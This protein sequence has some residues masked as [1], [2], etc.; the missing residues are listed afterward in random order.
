MS[1]LG[2]LLSGI[3]EELRQ[4]LAQVAEENVRRAVSAIADAPRVLVAG[5]GRSGLAVRAFAMRLMH[6]GKDVFVV[7]DVTTPAIQEGDLLLIGSGSG[8]TASLVAAADK[9][10]SLGAKIALFTM[11]P[12]SEIAQMADVVVQIP[13]PSPKADSGVQ[14]AQSIQPMGSLFEQCLFV[15]LD[16]LIVRLMKRDG[17]SADEM[18]TRHANLE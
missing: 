1:E 10:K 4:C 9:A 7:G 12:G 3:C 2:E 8:R 14:S 6:L 16:A 18:F 5:A 13:A 11:D 15:L 17:V